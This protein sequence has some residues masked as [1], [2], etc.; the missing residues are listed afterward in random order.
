MEVDRLLA[1]RH[2]PILVLDNIGVIN[3]AD[4][5]GD[6]LAAMENRGPSNSVAITRGMYYSSLCV[7]FIYLCR[8]RDIG[9]RLV[10]IWLSYSIYLYKIQIWV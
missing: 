10:F 6:V 7:C 5:F 8:L 9:T 4:V 3:I 2:V 1:A